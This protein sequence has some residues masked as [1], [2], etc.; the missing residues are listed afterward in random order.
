MIDKLFIILQ[1]FMWIYNIGIGK[2]S[3]ETLVSQRAGMRCLGPVS[4]DVR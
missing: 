4:S 1:L 3:F 2:Y